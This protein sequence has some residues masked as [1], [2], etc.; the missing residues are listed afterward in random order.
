MSHDD[1]TTVRSFVAPRVL[2]LPVVGCF[3]EPL[4][5]GRQAPPAHSQNILAAYQ[6]TQFMGCLRFELDFAFSGALR[7]QLQPP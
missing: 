2:P 6:L 5:L 3:S 1:A 4:L 7:S